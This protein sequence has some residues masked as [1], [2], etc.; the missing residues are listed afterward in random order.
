VGWTLATLGVGALVMHYAGREPIQMARMRA[1]EAC[2]EAFAFHLLNAQHG[3]LYKPVSPESPPEPL[4]ATVAGRDLTTVSGQTLTLVNPSRPLQLPQAGAPAP[5]RRR[6]HLTSL[7][8]LGPENAPDAWERQALERLERSQ[9]EV[10]EE[11]SLDGQRVLRL[12]SLL[13]TQR[14]CLK[15][16]E[17]Q[18]YHT[19]DVC[20]GLSVIEPLEF[21]SGA[22]LRHERTTAASLGVLWFLGLVGLQRGG[23]EIRRRLQQQTLTH[24]QLEAS[25]R[26]FRALAEQAPV[27]IYETDGTGQFTYVNHRWCAMTGWS[28]A[29]V[30]Q[31]NWAQTLH[32]EDREAVLAGWQEHLRTGQRWSGDY[33]G[34]QPEGGGTWLRDSAEAL[35]DGA[36][37]I[38][39]YLGVLTDLTESRLA[40]ESLRASEERFRLGFESAPL[41]MILTD[42]AGRFLQLNKA[43]AAML[44]YE[45]VELCQR[46]LADVSHPDDLPQGTELLRRSQGAPR[47]AFSLALRYLRKDGATVW[48]DVTT[49][50]LQR[51]NGQAL[52]HLAM[53]QDTTERRQGE[54]RL[55]EQAALLDIAQDAICVQSLAG[56]IEFWN[57]AAEKLYGWTGAEAL[58]ANSDDLLFGRVSQELLQARTEVLTQGSW[59]GELQQAAR[60]GSVIQVHSRFS[61]V[62]DAQG[63][64][65]SIL[66]VSTDLTPH[67]KLEQQLLRTQRLECIGSLA[68]GVAHDLNN[69]FS[70]IL[71]VAELLASRPADA[72]DTEL[73]ALL[74][75]SA[76]RGA[77]IVRQLL[78]FSR[79]QDIDRAELR[80]E[81]LLREMHR[82]ARETFPKNIQV[83]VRPDP[84][85]WP[86]V[87]D[88]TQ[89]HQMLL[90]LCLNARDAMPGGGS[91]TLEARNFRADSG[92]CKTNVEARPGPYVLLQVTDTGGGIPTAIRDQI[93]DPFFTTKPAGQGTG[94][95]LSTVRSLVKA[96]RGF[97]DAHSRPGDG[98]QFRVFLPAVE[99]GAAPNPPAHCPPALAGQGACVLVVDDEM[100][101]CLVARQLLT[102]HGYVPLV[103]LDGVEAISLFAQHQADIRFVLTDMMMPGMDGAA[104]IRAVRK[105]APSVPIVVMTGMSAQQFEADLAGQKQIAFLAKPFTAEAL[106]QAFQAF[107]PA[108]PVELAAALPG[109][110]DRGVEAVP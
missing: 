48:G 50:F 41:G 10:V 6:V 97:L 106:L 2:R 11:V 21:P 24:V 43:F 65:K 110:L 63:R 31:K 22:G 9:R 33:R 100:T 5:G 20:G 87:G 14:H 82:L 16:H 34:V 72:A 61:L 52:G 55:R 88:A 74:R 92:F 109:V 17:P 91:L 75:T 104:F 66:L 93:F 40:A 83:S 56:R 68:S 103:A 15:C 78:T 44:G 49:V 84:D 98:T 23:A 53:I 60:D 28:A 86:V 26:R 35:R 38:V 1:Q 70:P 79:G 67:K 102:N 73:L 107:P 58:G 80:V 51:T 85:V 99:H 7:R 96:H 12:L 81:L 71:M 30:L 95:G 77:G 57:P 4:L 101:I 42:A 90:N 76:D 59:T 27:G 89:I 29:M 64:P 54:S 45:P 19:G 105:L 46:S 108:A 39:G 25:E 62:R 8:P 3:G 13:T 69:V 94:L 32:P 36:G 37:Q 18:G 47:T